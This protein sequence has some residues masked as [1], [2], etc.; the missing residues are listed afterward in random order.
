MVLHAGFLLMIGRAAG[1]KLC[2]FDDENRKVS[3]V[4]RVS[5]FRGISKHVIG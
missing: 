1:Q 5:V 3:T 4:I 2:R